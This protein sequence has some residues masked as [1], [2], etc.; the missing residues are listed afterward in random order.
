[1]SEN[2]YTLGTVAASEQLLRD[3]YIDLRAKVK[4]WSAVTRQTP[5][6]RMGYIGQHLVS[7]VTGYPGARTGA[8]G[9]DLAISEQ[10]SG[11][12]K[13]C[14]RVDQLGSCKTC[15]AAVSSIEDICPACGSEDIDR[16]DDSKWLIN[17][18]SEEELARILDPLFYYFVLFELDSREPSNT[19]DIVVSI[20]QVDPKAK[21]F[22]YMLIDY[23]LN[24]RAFSTSKA[25]LDLWPYRIK[26]YMTNPT[27]I[28]RAVI[29][30][31]DDIH[32]S[33]FPTLGNGFI[34]ALPALPIYSHASTLKRETLVSCVQQIDPAHRVSSKNK[35]WLLS[36]M[37]EYRVQTGMNNAE[38]CDWL[39]STVYLPRLRPK[40]AL[41]PAN[42]LA[43]FPELAGDS[44]L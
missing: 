34:D 22:T 32:T 40:A 44:A 2:R 1:M 20:W 30:P 8:R 26:F 25:P 12:I 13:T 36:R 16:K 28:Y 15:M 21:G 29:T 19:S 3:L 38:V 4:R 31:E 43:V 35:E 27:L 33:V 37:E 24:I 7:V 23:Y 17:I 6:A 42:L 41:I 5:Q 9:R 11:E 18:R 14:Y 10:D 39:A